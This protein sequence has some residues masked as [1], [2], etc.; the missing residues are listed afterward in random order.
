MSLYSNYLGRQQLVEAINNLDYSHG[1]TNTGS[2][3]R[4]VKDNM[5]SG[6][7]GDRNGVQD[8]AI[9]LTDGGSNEKVRIICQIICIS[10]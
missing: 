9:V 1:T 3:L 8:V 10:L 6:F 2:A 5:F 4:Y 7:N